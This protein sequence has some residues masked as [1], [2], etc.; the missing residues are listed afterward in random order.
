M[1][2][3]SVSMKETKIVRRFFSI[4]EAGTLRNTAWN[5]VFWWI[6]LLYLEFVMHVRFFGEFSASVLYIVGFTGTIA[7][8]ISGLLGFLPARLNKVVSVVLVSLFSIVFCTQIVYEAVF[9]TMYSM[10][11]ISMGGAALTSFWR[12]TLIT[13]VACIPI[14]LVMLL[15]IPVTVLLQISVMK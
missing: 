2:E 15:S 3:N 1:F 8:V 11:Q 9:S 12:E 6:T 14:L 4:G 5:M 10:S 7:W 13:I